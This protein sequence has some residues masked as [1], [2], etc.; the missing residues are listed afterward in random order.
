[1]RMSIGKS[2]LFWTFFEP[3]AQISI[4]ISIHVLLQRNSHTASNYNYAV[5]IASSFIAF[6]MFRH[7]LR[8]SAGAFKANRGLFNYKQVKP[9]D[10]IIAR[11]LVEIFMTSIIFFVFLFVGFLLQL[12]ITPQ[13]PLIVFAAYI[14]LAFFSFGIGIVVGIG[15]TFYVSVEKFVGIFSY[16][17]LL[18]SAI[19]YPVESVP[20]QVRDLLLTNP[21]VHFMELIHAGYIETLTDRF[22][23]YTYMFVWTLT[24]LFIGLWL[25]VRLEKKIISL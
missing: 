4:F 6:N 8:S 20:P 9:I 24:P 17:L 22:V 3:F 2:G 5:F 14:W 11:G 25:Y 10:T 13:H 16:I 18:F 15:S 23:D 12:P 1:M 21:L 19:F 7:I